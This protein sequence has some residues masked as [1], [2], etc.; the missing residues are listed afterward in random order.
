MLSDSEI[1]GRMTRSLNEM[2]NYMKQEN[3]EYVF[4]QKRLTGESSA[5]A[6]D[7]TQANQQP[8]EP[9]PMTKLNELYEQVT[10]ALTAVLA[11]TAA[12]AHTSAA[13]NAYNYSIYYQQQLKLQQSQPSAAP[14]DPSASKDDHEQFAHIKPPILPLE[15][16]LKNA[17]DKFSLLKSK[18]SGFFKIEASNAKNTS[19]K[20]NNKNG[21]NKLI[22]DYDNDEDKDADLLFVVENKKSSVLSHTTAT[23]DGETEDGDDDD[24]DDDNSTF[25]N[26]LDKN[27]DLEIVTTSELKQQ[28]KKRNYL[29]PSLKAINFPLKASINFKSPNRFVNKSST[30][31]ANRRTDNSFGQKQNKLYDILYLSAQHQK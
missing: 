13:I 17:A 7:L 10:K 31:N 29:V 19:S 20:A 5:S 26:D 22:A 30:N 3:K 23:D 4:R 28:S 6:I 12:C 1:V 2:Y 18:I 14:L 16:E 21:L 24:D 11:H 8:E 27:C 15:T 25:F 9:S